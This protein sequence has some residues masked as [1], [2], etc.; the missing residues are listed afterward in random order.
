MEEDVV[1]P[2]E[3]PLAL[4]WATVGVIVMVGITV[5]PE[6]VESSGWKRQLVLVRL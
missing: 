4:G 3:A 5:W 6:A 2:L 1:S